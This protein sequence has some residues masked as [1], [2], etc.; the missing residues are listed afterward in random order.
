MI[1]SEAMIVS[2]TMMRMLG[3]MWLRIRLTEKFEP[4]SA[5]KITARHIT[6]EV[7]ILVVTA[8]AEQMPSTCS[9]IGL[10][11]NSGSMQNVFGFVCHQP[12]SLTS[13]P[14]VW[15]SAVRWRTRS[16]YGPSLG[17]GRARNSSCW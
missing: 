9:A 13:M 5:P 10:L 12:I 17:Q 4:T 2:W 16:R 7:S 14:V 8:R 15:T 11:L 1:T 6:A 3:G